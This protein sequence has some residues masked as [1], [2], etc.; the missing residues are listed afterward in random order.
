[1]TK[2]HLKTKSLELVKW[3]SPAQLLCLLWVSAIFEFEREVPDTSGPRLWPHNVVWLNT[4]TAFSYQLSYQFYLTI[5][6]LVFFIFLCIKCDCVQEWV[7]GWYDMTI[8]KG[9]T[10]DPWSTVKI[11]DCLSTHHHHHLHLF[12]IAKKKK[13]IIWHCQS[14]NFL[15]AL[16]FLAWFKV[17]SGSVIQT[18]WLADSA[19]I[20]TLL[21]YYLWFVSGKRF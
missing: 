18:F 20:R 2:F 13:N 3:Y 12:D 1:M 5:G 4:F 8:P 9:G 15:D 6:L 11:R 19:S 10:R 21:V 7:G 16:A 17:V 14:E